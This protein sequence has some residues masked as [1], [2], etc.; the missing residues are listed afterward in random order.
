M[1]TIKSWLIANVETVF[2]ALQVIFIGVIFIANL[3][4]DGPDLEDEQPVA[5]LG[6]ALGFLIYSSILVYSGKDWKAALFCAGLLCVALYYLLFDKEI[7]FSLSVKI[8]AIVCV[9]VSFVIGLITAISAYRNFDDV[10]SRRFLYR[11]S[12]VSVFE[13]QLLY[14]IN[15]FYVVFMASLSFVLEVIVFFIIM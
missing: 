11:N 3:V 12:D 5:L 14:A 7:E 15:R 9:A 4:A 6:M 8:G 13:N 10:V 2:I 1:N